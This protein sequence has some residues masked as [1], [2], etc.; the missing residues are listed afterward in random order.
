MT[1]KNSKR[2]GG[3]KTPG[4]KQVA[5]Q[6]SLKTGSYSN[7]AV[8]PGENPQEFEVLINQFD[9]D[10]HPVDVIE[11]SLVRDLAV[12]TWKRLRLQKLESDYFLKKQNSPITMEELIDCGLQFNQARFDF[13]VRETKLPE[14]YIDQVKKTLELIK[15]LQRV[16]ITVG[17][18]EKTRTMDPKVQEYLIDYYRRIDPL[19]L[20]EIED[21]ELVDK[22]VRFKG[23]SEK[24]LTSIVFEQLVEA[25]EAALWCTR[26]HEAINQAV[27]QI[28]QERV[29]KL[30]RSDGV[31]RVNDDLSRAFARTLSEFRKHH[32]WRLRN[33]VIDADEE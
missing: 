1:I 25:Y 30:M 31:R 24:F 12:L 2:S 23:Q 3:P 33:R 20:P 21:E 19:A 29:F 17:Q 27:F 15:P 4:G 8:L 13:W 10:F 6:N 32:E 14:E 18:L 26:K 16:G 11:T 28:K 22:T 5:A 9:H 7:L